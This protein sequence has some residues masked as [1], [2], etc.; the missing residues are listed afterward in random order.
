[1]ANAGT[2]TQSAG[3]IAPA[4][5]PVPVTPSSAPANGLSHD[6]SRGFSHA[7]ADSADASNGADALRETPRNSELVAGNRGS[8]GVGHPIDD[9]DAD[10]NVMQ[11]LKRV[12]Q[13]LGR[14]R[15]DDDAAG[16]RRL[17]NGKHANGD[18]ANGHAANGASQGPVNGTANPGRTNGS[19]RP[20]AA[21]E[22]SV[23][24]T[25]AREPGARGRASVRRAASGD[26]DSVQTSANLRKMMREL[27]SDWSSKVVSCADTVSDAE[28]VDGLAADER[29]VA[30][31]PP[32]R[33]RPTR[34]VLFMWNK[35]GNLFVYDEAEEAIN[36]IEIESRYQD[37]EVTPSDFQ[38]Y[39]RGSRRYPDKGIRSWGFFR[40]G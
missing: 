5:D 8:L 30:N 16:E 13:I 20:G 24:Q 28:A 3:A 11:R 2:V 38:R 34:K 35:A 6:Y 36:G 40:R 7:P 19:R 14:L 15:G 1:M 17:D 18:L 27:P 9:E 10:G 32:R 21:S 12:D 22:K 25:P 26:A 4:R 37:W 31:S 39:L 29:T 23:T 33:P